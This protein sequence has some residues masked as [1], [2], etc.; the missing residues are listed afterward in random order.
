VLWVP[1]E[2]GDLEMTLCKHLWSVVDVSPSNVGC[3]ECVRAGM[4]WVNLRIC[5]TCGYVGCCNGSLGKHASAHW[6]LNRGHPII[7]SFE[8]GE[9]WWWCFSDG[10]LFEVK[11]APRAPSH[12]GSLDGWSRAASTLPVCSEGG[13]TRHEAFIE[14]GLRRLYHYRGNPALEHEFEVSLFARRL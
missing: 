13:R 14:Q 3:D 7:R 10:L 2:V 4:H 8:P 9:D 11:G 5:M 12:G 1:A 6:L